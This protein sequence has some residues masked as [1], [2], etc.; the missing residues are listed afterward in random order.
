MTESAVQSRSTPR[1]ALAALCGLVLVFLA[2]VA[3]YA[4]ADLPGAL[5]WA[6]PSWML[7]LAAVGLAFYAFVGDRRIWVRAISGVSVGLFI[8]GLIAFF[9]FTRLPAAAAPPVG[10]VAPDFALADE[11][12]ATVRLADA[13]AGGP[14]FLAFYRGFW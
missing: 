1:R 10:A 2:P 14:V 3:Y 6:W 7:M 4:T 5:R 9:V 8:F 11:N 13:R 12:G